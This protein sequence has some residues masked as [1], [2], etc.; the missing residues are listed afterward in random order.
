MVTDS[1]NGGQE[2]PS[3][4]RGC[5]ENDIGSSIYWIS[6]GPDDMKRYLYASDGHFNP[7]GNRLVAQLIRGHILARR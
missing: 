7:E 5:E 3:R 6:E 4:I 2:S 1:R